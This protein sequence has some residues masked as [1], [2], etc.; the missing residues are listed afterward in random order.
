MLFCYG[1]DE[2]GGK[3]GLFVVVFL[4]E[5]YVAFFYFA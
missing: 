2:F 1:G 3:F 4:Y 5:V